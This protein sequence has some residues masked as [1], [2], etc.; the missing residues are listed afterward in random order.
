MGENQGESKQVLRVIG[1]GVR[2]DLDEGI[3]ATGMEKV[4]GLINRGGKVIS[5]DVGGAVL[6]NLN[7][8]D[9]S[10]NP[11]MTFCGCEIKVTIDVSGLATSP[12]AE[13]HDRLYQEG[14][15]LINPYMHIVGRDHQSADTEK[16]HDELSRGKDLLQQVLKINPGNGSAWWI[17][18]KAEQVLK[19]TEAACDAFRKAYQLRNDN[20]DTA[21]EYMFECLKLGRTKQAIAAARH[22]RE[23]KPNDMGL[24]ANL[25]LALMIGGEL[26]EAAETIE[27][28]LAGAPDDP[29]SQKLKQRIADI[30]AGIKPQPHNLGDLNA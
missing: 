19:D 4:N 5:I 24:V 13:E 23:L 11:S 17:I 27:V 6:R 22:A 10:E 28:A 1:V 18:G 15:D 21:R 9:T 20:A 2:I 7:K 16:A 12:V 3:S 29:I 26:E 8:N 30:R 14:L 25:G